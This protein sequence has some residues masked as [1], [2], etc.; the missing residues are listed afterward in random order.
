DAQLQPLSEDWLKELT[1]FAIQPE[2]GAVGGKILA[3]NHSIADGG[4][5]IGFDGSIGAA[6]RGLSAQ[7]DRNLF[8][9]LVINNFS[10]VSA[11]CLAVRRTAF[12]SV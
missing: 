3:P 5:V 9:A 12:D 2:I 1:S 11:N 8:R 6:F 4:L 7:T 10:A